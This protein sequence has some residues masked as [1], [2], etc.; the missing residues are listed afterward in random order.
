VE[1][2]QRAQG[3]ERDRFASELVDWQGISVFDGVEIKFG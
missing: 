2:Q 1:R 3:V